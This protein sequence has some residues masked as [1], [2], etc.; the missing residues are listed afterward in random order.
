MQTNIQTI[1][2]LNLFDID[3]LTHCHVCVEEDWNYSNVV[4]SFSR[5]FYVREGA[6]SILCNGRKILLLPGNVYLVPAGTCASY[7]CEKGGHLDKLFFHISLLSTDNHDLLSDLP[8]TIYELSFAQAGCEQIFRLYQAPSYQTL[9]TLRIILYQTLLEF[10][11]HF[12]LPTPEMKTY[13]AVTQSVVRYIQN[14]F[15]IALTIDCIA[16]ANFVSKGYLCKLFKKEIG[17][18][19]GK[20]IDE[21]ALFRAKRMLLTEKQRTIQQISAALGFHDQAYFS[22]RFKEKT[23]LSPAQYR[24]EQMRS[25]PDFSRGKTD[26]VSL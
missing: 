16:E 8:H 13:S 4:S 23:G 12:S 14:H 1:P 11:T 5:L 25:L 21:Q 6:A 22:R 19:I 10:Y 9:L 3:I 7:H 26:S 18:S 15:S 20:Y 17:I 24:K 2:E